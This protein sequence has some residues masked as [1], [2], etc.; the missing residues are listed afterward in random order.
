[1]WTTADFNRDRLT[2][3]RDFNIW[4]ANKL[5]GVPPIVATLSD[6]VPLRVP[7]AALPSSA[8]ERAGAVLLSAIDSIFSR[9]Q[10]DPAPWDLITSDGLDVDRS[11]SD[12]PLDGP[13]LDRLFAQ[14]DSRLPRR[15]APLPAADKEGPGE[16]RLSN[17]WLHPIDH[18]GFG[19]RFW[20]MCGLHMH[21]SSSKP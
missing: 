6:G 12:A 17:D 9:L 18:E 5:L 15:N 21:E 1:M 4:N 13:N 19:V 11:V 10:T 14:L 16:A 8:N 3:V 2:D 20:L 7:R